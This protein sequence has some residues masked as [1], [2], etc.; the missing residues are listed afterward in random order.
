VI[1]HSQG[2]ALEMQDQ[3][4]QTGQRQPTNCETDHKNITRTQAALPE[5]PQETDRARSRD[6]GTA[7]G[8]RGLPKDLLHLVQG[9]QMGKGDLETVAL[10]M[11]PLAGQAV[12]R[13]QIGRDRETSEVNGALELMVGHQAG[14][15]E[16]TG[17]PQSPSPKISVR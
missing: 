8:R 11:R 7:T 12:C 16:G 6:R 2:S 17:P 13:R 3:M 10:V 1:S 5:H 15:A 4:A 9:G 14:S